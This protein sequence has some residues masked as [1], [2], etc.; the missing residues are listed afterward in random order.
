MEGG[1]YPRV[2]LDTLA[3]CQETCGG[4]PQCRAYSFNTRDRMCYLKDVIGRYS[5][6]ADVVSGEKGG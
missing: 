1:D 2:R 6:R 3:A 4:E 5:P